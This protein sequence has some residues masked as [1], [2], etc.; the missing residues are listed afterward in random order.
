MGMS[1]RSLSATESQSGLQC[2][3]GWYKILRKGGYKRVLAGNRKHMFLKGLIFTGQT[4]RLSA[5]LTRSRR[6]SA[7]LAQPYLAGVLLVLM[8]LPPPRAT[9]IIAAWF[10]GRFVGRPWAPN[11]FIASM[12]CASRGRSVSARASRL[13]RHGLSGDDRVHFSSKWTRVHHGRSRRSSNRAS[14]PA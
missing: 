6:F 8:F 5:S 14:A 10:V 7:N 2:A 3:L 12:L 13:E 11:N 1:G 4:P 9:H